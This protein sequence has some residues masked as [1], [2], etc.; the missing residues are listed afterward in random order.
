MVVAL[1]QTQLDY[2]TEAMKALE[3]DESEKAQ[4]LDEEL[5]ERAVER[6]M[7]AVDPDSVPERASKKN[8]P[9]A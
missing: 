8:L 5:Q 3:N 4:Q 1:S 9:G 7:A 6:A 2:Q